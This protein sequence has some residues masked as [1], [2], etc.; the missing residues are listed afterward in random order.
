M[1]IWCAQCLEIYI[2]CYSKY[3]IEIAFG[4]QTFELLIG[5]E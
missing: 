5:F 4:A 1:F 3:G 2:S